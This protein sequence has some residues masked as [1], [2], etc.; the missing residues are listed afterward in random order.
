MKFACLDCGSNYESPITCCCP[1]CGSGVINQMNMDDIQVFGKKSQRK[2]SD[3]HRLSSSYVY[4]PKKAGLPPEFVNHTVNEYAFIEDYE[5][6]PV[7]VDYLCF[8]V[9]MSDFRHCKKESPYSGIH[10]PDEPKFS[11]HQAKFFEDIE[12]YNRY[13]REVYMDYLQECV[14]RFIQYV[15]GFNYGAP[16]GRGFQFYQDSFVLTSEFGDDYC[17]QVGFGGNRDTIHFQITGHGCKHLFAQRSCRFLHHW[18]STILCCKQLARIDL[19]FDD[20]DGLHTCEA[21]ERAS[22]LGAFKRSRG[23][24]P[25]IKSG[26]EWEWA[27]DGSKIFTREE[28]N[29]GSRQSHVYW[30][31]YN[32]KLEQNID[33]E[34]FQWYRS[35]VEL[36]KWDTDILLNPLAGFVALNAYAASLISEDVT[37]VVTKTKKKKRMA[38]DVLASAFWAKRQYGRVVN[39]LLSLY[40]GDFEKVVTTLVRD[41]KVLSYPSMHQKLINALE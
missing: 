12:A 5:Q 23:F 11:T 6:S 32:K 18:L 38:C 16:R 13:F 14:R 3:D 33:A 40:Q 17:G 30:R 10:F 15:L 2:K 22:K 7:I 39:S 8:T 27:E 28:R 31:I 21:A 35:E 34:D 24:A 41:D 37:P 9:N 29:F 25:K 4:R 26:D 20:F 19:A 36:K 1:E